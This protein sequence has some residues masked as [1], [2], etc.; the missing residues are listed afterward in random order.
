MGHKCQNL[1][2]PQRRFIFEGDV[3]T[4]HLSFCSST[5]PELSEELEEVRLFLFNDL[6]VIASKPKFKPIASTF[7][8]VWGEQEVELL[9][10]EQIPILN[11]TTGTLPPRSET[12]ALFSFFIQYKTFCPDRFYCR[13]LTQA[14]DWVRIIRNTIVSQS[15]K[16]ST[17]K[18][19]RSEEEDPWLHGR[20]SI[21]Y[22]SSSSLIQSFPSAPQTPSQTPT[23][24]S[25]S[26]LS[27][28]QTHSVP[29]NIASLFPSPP[30][31]DPTPVVPL[32]P[33]QQNVVG[34][35]T[36]KT[37]LPIYF[38]A[39]K[40]LNDL[41][42]SPLEIQ[43]ILPDYVKSQ[44]PDML[45][46]L[47]SRLK[48]LHAQLAKINHCKGA[49][50]NLVGSESAFVQFNNELLSGKPLFFNLFTSIKT[51]NLNLINDQV[52]VLVQWYTNMCTLWNRILELP[53]REAPAK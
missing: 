40:L 7:K 2:Q 35:S 29:Q 8:K 9:F 28:Q 14:E 22:R 48:L 27:V 37:L 38:E 44:P 12:D 13:T 23:K 43:T 19:E 33:S 34:P 32:I 25:N 18:I 51:N 15:K 20:R 39:I 30:S 46:T 26:K 52:K 24:S 10:R 36:L 16:L 4:Q 47:F 50:E 45:S 11:S 1:I 49:I 17:L 31:T 41:F 6:L 21:L 53:L 3:F 5:E 42:K